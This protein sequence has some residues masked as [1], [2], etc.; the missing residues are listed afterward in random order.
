MAVDGGDPAA[1]AAAAEIGHKIE[2]YQLTPEEEAN[3]LKREA[4]ENNITAF[5]N[6]LFLPGETTH[7]PATLAAIKAYEVD[8]SKIP[9]APPQELRRCRTRLVS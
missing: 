9:K 2:M 1:A 8:L 5:K 7:H 4:L 3:R 6:N